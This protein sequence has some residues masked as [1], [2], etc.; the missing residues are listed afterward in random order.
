LNEVKTNLREEKIEFDQ[1]VKVGVMIEVPS[2]AMT[3]DLLAKEADFFSIGTND[4]I[5]YTLAVDRVNEQTDKFY[6]PGHPAILRLI[7]QT[8]EAAHHNKIPVG[9]CGEMSSEPILALILLGMGLDEFS[10]SAASIL[11]IKMLIRSVRYE[12]ARELA[13]DV[14]SLSTGEEVEE[15]SKKRLQ[16]LAPNIINSEKDY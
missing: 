10:M 6:D 16:E 9:L 3:A 14:M 1:E 7:K 4:L 11:Q 2:A 15:F 13:A 5:Q 8:I 12:D